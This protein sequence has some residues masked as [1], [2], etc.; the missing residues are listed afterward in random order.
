MNTIE[1]KRWDNAEVIHSGK[2]SSVK[3]C[4]E[5][6]IENGISFFR[7]NLE[8]ANLY[9]AN[10]EGADLCDAKGVLLF[11]DNQSGRIFYAINH[12]DK[13]MFNAG[14][15]WGSAEDLRSKIQEEGK[16]ET[17]WDYLM[18]IE[19]AERAFNIGREL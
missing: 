16:T 17:H 9:E 14:C 13:V 6:G 2:F 7:A 12:T 11:K 10:L 19:W 3:E 5:D 8:G 18:A 15:F 1:I 4:L